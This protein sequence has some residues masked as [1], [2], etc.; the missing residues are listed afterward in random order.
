MPREIKIDN[1]E[2]KP[3]MLPQNSEEM[4]KEINLMRGERTV[5]ETGGGRS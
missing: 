4:V 3:E 5:T 2:E 1:M